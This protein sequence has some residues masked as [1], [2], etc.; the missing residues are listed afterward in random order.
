MAN[1]A[2][3]R[4]VRVLVGALSATILLVAA[5]SSSPDTA[6]TDSTTTTTEPT[7]REPTIAELA[8]VL[9]T[10]E[11]V[12]GGLV[13]G[14]PE[15]LADSDG[16][17]QD[18]GE[19]DAGERIDEVLQERCPSLAQHISVDEF[20]T[21]TDRVERSFRGPGGEGIVVGLTLASTPGSGF[22]NREEFERILDLFN[23]CGEIED[24]TEEG[25]MSASFNS[26]TDDRFGSFQGTVSM[27][28]K[29]VFNDP[30]FPD[31]QPI[32]MTELLYRIGGVGVSVTSVSFID[33][34]GDE[35]QVDRNISEGVAAH[36]EERLRALQGM[37]P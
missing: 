7:Y 3:P 14:D 5:C 27:S 6:S 31:I 11:T 13:E 32:H 17:D 30:R 9:P 25:S 37:E 35:I 12:G 24:S 33:R 22:E 29:V 1:S 19:P 23:T 8:A 34:L 15:M 10:A 21:A 20:G 18:S 28:M 36:L 2:K 16:S 26:W 4:S